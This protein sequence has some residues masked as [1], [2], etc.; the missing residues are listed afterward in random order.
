[1]NQ[2]K[3]NKNRPSIPA[4]ARRAVEVSAGHVCTI[5]GCREHTYL[6]IHHINE[7]REDNCEDNLILLCDKHHKMA[8]KGLISR[9]ALRDYKAIRANEMYIFT[10]LMQPWENNVSQLHYINISR[11]AILSEILGYK[12][13]TKYFENLPSLN[14]LG[15]EISGVLREFTNL[16]NNI[17]P[18]SINL[19]DI[20][21]T[22]DDY[23]G[24]TVSFNRRFYT[25]NVPGYDNFV[26]GKYKIVGNHNL[27]PQIHSKV[28]DYKV[29]LNIDP[30]WL[31]TVTSFVNMRSG[32]G[33][34]AGLCTIKDIYHEEKVIVATPI[35]IGVP[36]SPLDLLFQVPPEELPRTISIDEDDYA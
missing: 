35:I 7:N 29:I 6:Y 23:I 19:K 24:L 17:N 15:G 22:S 34:F 33:K 12:I 2:S 16:L 3:Y 10:E 21:P 18:K 36:K 8:H 25:K 27:D 31:T 26:N 11:L 20:E 28:N 13:D 32:N 4:E 5:K 14:S 30:R 1:M 9:K